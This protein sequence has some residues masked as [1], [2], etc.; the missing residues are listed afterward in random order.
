MT[1][2]S[3][4]CAL[5]F[6]ACLA[7]PAM[8]LETEASHAVL[9]DYDTGQTLLAKQADV[10]M[11]PSSMSKLM[12]SYIVY[13]RLKEGAI[14]L[15]D[16]FRVSEKAWRMQGSKM[17]VHV[18]DL[19]SVEDLL[20][21]IVVQSGNDACIVV[22]EGI[23]GSEE[24]FAELMNETAKEIGLT[25]SHFT[26]ATGWPDENHQMSARDLAIL[27]ERI[28]K[29]FP[30]YYDFYSL[31]SYTYSDITQPNRNRLLG[32]DIGV[33]GL[34]TGHTEVAGYGI[35]LSA[36]HPD[37]G[38][39][40]I[41]VVNGLASDNARVEEGDRLL[42]WGFQSFE[43]LT[44]AK[45]GKPLAEAKVWL[46][47]KA[48][49]ALTTAEDVALTL[50]T[51]KRKDITFTLRYDG[52]IAAP[53]TQG[54]ELAELVITAPEMEPRVVKLVAAEDVAA[55][56]GIGRASAVWSERLIGQ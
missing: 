34:K 1:Y 9:V 26:N 52:P 17:F 51:A 37:S 24:A 46:G 55:L 30:Q 3:R 47:K 49:V 6:T 45:A 50:P 16:T 40:L 35:T 14:T 31:Q 33:D 15:E 28:I 54:A 42:R 38:R 20:K 7:M 39:R 2:L 25:Q 53:I 48:R 41:L 23:S 12:T 5:V 32:N 22:A 8:A 4:L 19:V 44:I 36:K 27:A 10:K 43:N 21:G 56:S 13:Q 29:D 18:G 11:H